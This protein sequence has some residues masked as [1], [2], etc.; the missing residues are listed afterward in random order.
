MNY[1]TANI[2]QNM[3]SI[4]S[5]YSTIITPTSDILTNVLLILV[6]L[7]IF[8]VCVALLSFCCCFGSLG[9]YCTCKTIILGNRQ[10][11][12]LIRIPTVQ[13]NPSEIQHYS[14]S[15]PNL[16]PILNNNISQSSVAVN[17]YDLNYMNDLLQ[18]VKKNQ[19]HL[20]NVDETKIKRIVEQ[21]I[22]DALNKIRDKIMAEAQT[23]KELETQSK[24]SNSNIIMD[25]E[26][27]ESFEKEKHD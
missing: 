17:K 21:K 16:L 13:I 10:K 12:Y 4:C 5:Q 1:Y 19:N 22:E 25:E 11:R 18:Q 27:Q 3:H 15:V 20:L 6:I 23:E 14:A 7:G 2:N 26:K 9:L 8:I 24:Q